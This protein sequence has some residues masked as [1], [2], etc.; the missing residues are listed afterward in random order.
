[1]KQ[2]RDTLNLSKSNSV[3]TDLEKTRIARNEADVKWLIAMLESNWINPFSAK[4]QDLV[5]L[6]TG[7]VAT[8]KLSGK[9]IKI[10]LVHSA[11]RQIRQS[12]F[13]R[14]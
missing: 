13:T 12:N 9:G 7:K 14:P 10:I 5:C 1:M 2:M 11:W 8:Q 3:D 6:F 4:Q